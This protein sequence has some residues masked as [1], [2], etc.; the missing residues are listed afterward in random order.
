VDPT[1]RPPRLHFHSKD[2]VCRLAQFS[3]SSLFLC[4][5]Y[6]YF[7]GVRERCDSLI[8]VP[9]STYYLLSHSRFSKKNSAI[10]RDIVMMG[11]KSTSIT[12]FPLS[13]ITALT[14]TNTI[15]TFSQNGNRH[16]SNPNLSTAVYPQCSTSL[17]PC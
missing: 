16:S 13:T 12:I 11:K 2:V 14:L 8:R 17:L 5:L 6:S 4:S 1:L 9:L 15:F 10:N 7:S 3:L